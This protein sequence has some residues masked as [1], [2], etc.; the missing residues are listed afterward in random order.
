LAPALT[1]T[2]SPKESVSPLR[3]NLFIGLLSE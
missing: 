1:A 2:S 3:I